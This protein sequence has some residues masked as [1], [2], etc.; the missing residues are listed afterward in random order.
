M[1]THQA[2]LPW[3][4]KCWENHPW[5]P[6]YENAESAMKIGS[7]KFDWIPVPGLQGNYDSIGSKTQEAPF[8]SARG[9]AFILFFQS[10]KASEVGR[11][12][13]N[14]AKKFLEDKQQQT[15]K[16]AQPH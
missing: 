14:F 12:L 3:G 4:K 8:N 6:G 7:L 16:Q 5:G 10:L 1:A 9:K 15:N 11:Q 13:V 2:E